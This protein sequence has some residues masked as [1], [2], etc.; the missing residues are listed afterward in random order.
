MLEL[1]CGAHREPRANRQGAT[2][3]GNDAD[4]EKQLEASFSRL[5]VAHDRGHHLQDDER[6]EQVADERD[7]GAGPG[8]DDGIGPSA[9]IALREQ[10]APQQRGRR[11]SK[12]DDAIDDG[13]H[14]GY[15]NATP[16]EEID[17]RLG[18]F[19]PVG[20]AAGPAAALAAD[21]G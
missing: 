20:G 17:R 19:E 8:I 18:R 15:E 5:E 3:G 2:C 16:D 11:D 21:G 7:D 9:V 14:R 1:L 13:E 10:P 12:G 4:D 6:Q